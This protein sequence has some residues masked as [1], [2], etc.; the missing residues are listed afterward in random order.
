MAA[1]PPYR[2]GRLLA[3]GIVA[4]VLAGSTAIALIAFEVVSRLVRDDWIGFVPAAESVFGIVTPA[5]LLGG[6]L[7]GLVVALAARPVA[8]LRNRMVR[9]V[10][11]TALFAAGF[12]T[13]AAIGLATGTPPLTP[14]SAA[15][16]V[17]VAVLCAWWSFPGFD[18][19]AADDA[20]GSDIPSSTLG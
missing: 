6:A 2:T 19:E 12:G 15:A 11:F 5:G 18:R 16:V 10:L 20:T 17:G 4:G 13:V 14:L 9:R 7:Y 3:N 1:H 8:R